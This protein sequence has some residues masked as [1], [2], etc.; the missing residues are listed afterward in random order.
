[1]K[2]VEY[3][4]LSETISRI[5]KIKYSLVSASLGALIFA[6]TY[7]FVAYIQRGYHSARWFDPVNN[8]NMMEFGLQKFNPVTDAIFPG[9]CFLIGMALLSCGIL[10]SVRIWREA[11]T[12]TRGVG[13][14]G[15]SLMYIS[16]GILFLMTL[17]WYL[18]WLEPHWESVIKRIAPDGS[19]LIFYRDSVW[20]KWLIS[21]KVISFLIGLAEIGLGIVQLRKARMNLFLNT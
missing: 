16:L 19:Q 17:V 10:H 5:G 11:K 1:V 20:T 4:Q 9:L 8:I 13:N 18:G 6:V 7:L 12:G 14:P 21:W 3:P 2:T 15:F